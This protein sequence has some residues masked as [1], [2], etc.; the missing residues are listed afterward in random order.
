MLTSWSTLTQFHVIISL[1]HKMVHRSL[2]NSASSFFSINSNQI[3]STQI[4]S[5]QLKSTLSSNP[6]IRLNCPQVTNF[7]INF[8]VGIQIDLIWLVDRF[9]S[10]TDK[11]YPQYRE[12]CHL[13]DF[14]KNYLHFDDAFIPIRAESWEIWIDWTQSTSS[15]CA[16]WLSWACYVLNVWWSWASPRVDSEINYR[17]SIW[18]YRGPKST[19]VH[20]IWITFTI[21]TNW[22]ICILIFIS[23]INLDSKQCSSSW[24]GMFP[25]L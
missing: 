25:R 23:S 6:E 15:R 10:D 5:N 7:P 16:M 1:L 18:M 11:I 22:I 13:I 21:V 9:L 2:E 17:Y 14:I 20:F 19:S 12:G 24:F 3:N 8:V 4:K